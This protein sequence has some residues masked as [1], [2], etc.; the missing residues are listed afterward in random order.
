MIL[1]DIKKLSEEIEEHLSLGMQLRD[2]R[3]FQQFTASR[4]PEN[5]LFGLSI[6]L[7]HKFFGN[8]KVNNPV[9]KIILKDINKLKF[10]KELNLRIADRG[11][12]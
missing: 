12:F 10:L 5:F 8:N 6:N 9:K 2:S 1:R 11:I 3:I 4:K 7:I